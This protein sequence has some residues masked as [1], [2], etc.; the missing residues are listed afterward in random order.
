LPKAAL[1]EPN[2]ARMAPGPF[3]RM[4]VADYD[5][6]GFGTIIYLK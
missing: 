2:A 4:I 6:Q 3:D 5:A 1:S